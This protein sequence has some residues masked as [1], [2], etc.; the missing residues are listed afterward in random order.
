MKLNFIRGKSN[1]TNLA[2]LDE[3]EKSLKLKLQSDLNV[4]H[5]N[6]NKFKNFTLK[7]LLFFK[8]NIRNNSNSRSLSI[9]MGPY[10]GVLIPYIFLFGKNYLYLFDAWPKYHIRIANAAN[11]FNIKIIFF[12]SSQATNLFNNSKFGINGIWV[13]EGICSRGYYFND[14]SDKKI[15]VLEFGRKYNLYH[16]KIKKSLDMYGYVHY[17]EEST[18]NVVFRTH[19]S[20]V[21]GLANSKISICIPSNITHPLRAEGISTM[22][23]R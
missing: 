16:D 1:Q 12:S 6:K 18:D 23:L 9:L 11:L 3:F 13:P 17:Y 7:F 20:F 21:D 8:I 22:T 2:C 19:K 5:S 10:F 4:K 15:D 14:F